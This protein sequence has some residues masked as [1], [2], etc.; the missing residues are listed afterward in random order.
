MIR[1]TG[2]GAILGVL[3]CA[4]AVGAQAMQTERLIMVG[5]P[6][7]PAQKC[8]VLKCWRDKAGNKVCQVQALDSGELMTIVEEEARPSGGSGMVRVP[9]PAPETKV[10]RWGGQT[11]SPPL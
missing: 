2:L 10:V 1:S 3:A 6:D 11:S 5:E 7:K 9:G 4:A 8:R